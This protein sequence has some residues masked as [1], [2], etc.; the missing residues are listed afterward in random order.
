M[1]RKR[2]L[3]PAP[4]GPTIPKICRSVT[5]SETFRRIVLFPVRTVRSL[6]SRMPGVRISGGADGQDGMETDLLVMAGFLVKA[7]AHGQGG[8][9]EGED[10][11]K[12]NKRG[13]P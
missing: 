6:I 1:A 9:A 10:K 7:E 3:L 8:E 13:S 12:Q 4:D 11:E 5:A 2:V